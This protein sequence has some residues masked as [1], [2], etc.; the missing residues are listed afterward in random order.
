MLFLLYAMRHLFYC[1][2]KYYKKKNHDKI[3][4]GDNKAALD[5]PIEIEVSLKNV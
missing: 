4:Q 1:V 2:L 3:V 5:H